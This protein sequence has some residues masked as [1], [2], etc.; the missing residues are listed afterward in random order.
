MYEDL[1]TG[2]KAMYKVEPVVTDEGEV[3]IY[4]PHITEFS[5]THGRVIEEIGYHVRGYFVAQWD[6]FESVPWVVLAHSTHLKGIG[7]YVD[8]V[9]TTRI[10]V[11]LASS[12]SPER[13]AAVNLTYRDPETIDPAE[14]AGRED[15][16]ILMLPRAGETLYRLES[17]RP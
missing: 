10:R 16:G 7:S 11:S 15:E 6:R 4:A 12:I 1:W 17:A 9:E 2:A 5:F 8:G 3:I 14:F 13:C